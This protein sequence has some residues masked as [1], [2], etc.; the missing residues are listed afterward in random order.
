MT[1]EARST[2][3]SRL[4]KVAIAL[5]VGALASQIGVGSYVSA[6][7]PSK[8][9]VT[10]IR[11]DRQVSP[12]TVA[13]PKAE[14]SRLAAAGPNVAAATKRN[15]KPRIARAAARPAITGS[16]Y[17]ETTGG[18][19][20]TWTNY[21]NAGGYEGQQIAAFETIQVSCRLNG[22]KVPDGNTWWYQITSSPWSYAYYATADAFYN[23]GQTSGPLKGTPFFDPNVPIC[24]S[25]GGYNETTGGAANTWTDYSD[26]GGT[27]GQTIGSHATVQVTC[28]V[29]GFRVADGNTWW[30]QVASSPWNNAFFVSADA[31]YNNGQ[32][33]GSLIGTPF[34]DPSVP[35]CS[36]GAVTGSGSNETTGGAAHTWSDYSDAGGTEGQTIVAFTTVQIACKVTGFQVQDGNTWWYQIASSPWDNEYYVTADAF[37]N[38]GAT[39]G[40]LLGTPFV[41]TAVPNCS[42]GPRPGTETTGG[43]A[44]TWANYSHAGGA[45]GP[46]VPI[47]D[48]I[49][50]ACRVTGFAVSDANSWWYQIASAPWNYAYYVSADAFYN[51]GATSGSLVGT[52]FVDTSIPICVGNREAPIYGTS[53]GS[54]E[55]TTNSTSCPSGAHP[56]DCASGDFWHT[57]TD[58]SIPGR[59]P[60]LTL[61]RT[62]N[63]LDAGTLGLF[64]YGWTSSYEQHLTLTNSDASITPDGSITVTL[65][66]GS[67]F[68]AEP[69]GTGGFSV[70]LSA[71]STLVQNSDGTYTLTL[72]ATQVLTFSAIGALLSLSDLNGDRTTLT[73][74]GSSQLT[75]VTDSAGRTLT[76]NYGS[77]G[78]VAS[79]AD[80][81]GRTTTYT[82]DATNDLTSVTD[83]LG[84]TWTFTYDGSHR[85]L[86]MTDPRG[87]VVTNVYDPTGR[88]T[89]QTDADGLTTTYSYTGDN[90]SSLGGTTTITDPHGNVEVQQYANGFVTTVTKAEGTSAQGTWSYVYDPNTF[91]VT[92]ATDPNGHVTTNS[93]DP[94]GDLLTTTDPLGNETSYTY[95]GLDEVLTRTTPL[96]EVSPKTYDVEG[97]VLTSTDAVGNTTIYAYGDTTHPGDITSITDPDGRV[98]SFTYDAD[99]DVASKSVE[100]TSGTLDTTTFTVDSDGEQVCEASANADGITCP[101]AGSPHE[102]GTTTTVYDADGEVTSVTDANGNTTSR[103]YDADGNMIKVADPIGNET[104]STYDLDDR[105]VSTET[106]ANGTSP[107]TTS[108]SYDVTPGQGACQAVSGATYCRTTTDPNGGMTIEY[109]D[110]RG[111]EIEAVMPGGAET[112]FTYD[113]NGNKTSATDAAARVTTYSYDADDRLTSIVYSDG[114]T[115]DVTY[116]YDADGER[117]SMADGTGTTTYTY[118]ADGRVTSVTD[119]RGSVAGYAYDGQEDVTSLT[120]PNGQRVVR[121]YDGAERLVSVTDWLGNETTFAYDPSGNLTRTGYPNGDTVTSTYDA[122]NAL[123]ATSVSGTAGMLA[124][125]TYTRNADG[126]ITQETR[127]GAI[128]GS[129]AY[130]F[131]A[132]AE[133][134]SAGGTTFAYDLDGNLT[135]NGSSAQTFNSVDELTTTTSGVGATTYGYDAIGDR[136]SV[137]P[138]VGP[139]TDYSYDQ[140]GRLTSASEFASP[141]AVSSVAPASGPLTGGATVTISGSGFTSARAVTFGGVAATS[142][143]VVSDSE[144]R[145]DAPAASA[146]MVD[147]TVTTPFGGSPSVAGDEYTYTSAPAVTGITPPTGPTAGG[148]TVTITGTGLTGAT[149]VAF[150]TVA[151]VS[152]TV[153][154]STEITAVS[155]AH[156]AGTVGIIVTTPGGESALVAPD[157]FIFG[158]LPTVTKISPASGPLAGGTVVS[159]T[160]TG[161]SS[162]SRVLFGS[163]PAKSVT[164]LSTAK[165][166]AVSPAQAAANVQISVTTSAGTSPPVTADQ[167]SYLPIP[168]VTGVSPT[169]GSTKGGTTVSISGTGFTGATKVAFGAAAATHLTVASSTEI[170]VVDPAHA[171]GAVNVVVTGPGGKSPAVATSK[172]TYTTKTKVVA[173][174]AQANG[175]AITIQLASYA[176]NGDG[177][178]VT[179]S[180]S[181]GVM[182]F[183][184]DAT[185]SVPELLTDGSFDY[186]YGPAGLPIEQIDASNTAAYFFHDSDGSTRALLAANGAV[187]ATFTY[188]AYGA[189]SSSTGT[190]KTALLFAQTYSDPA[191]GL[192]YAVHRFY[193]PNTA[194]FTSVDPIVSQT[195]EPYS[196]ASD[197]PI[198]DRD[199]NGSCPWWF[200]CPVW[201]F[202]YNH[203]EAAQ[204]IG[205]IA[206]IV[207][208]AV[209]IVG[210]VFTATGL[211][212]DDAQLIGCITSPDASCAAIRNQ[213]FFDAAVD[214]LGIR[215][216]ELAS[217]ALSIFLL[218]QGTAGSPG[219]GNLSTPVVTSRMAPRC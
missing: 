86:T 96:G 12:R 94:A 104:L 164:R 45:E 50:I 122:T 205:T 83:P 212:V 67:Q 60:G 41:D 158:S 157:Q 185:T 131:D 152:F 111:N 121:A 14:F 53:I 78:L 120:Y 101:P 93:Y 129:T 66:D 75:A 21:T 161:F 160:G 9:P 169:S 7:A 59:G 33:T 118:N 15:S 88:V 28:A 135:A 103:T 47:H 216:P 141:P 58:V 57:F 31:F 150:G 134:S 117:A 213:A 114:V 148:T 187:G 171:K 18:A 25:G 156:A 210:L 100:P 81:L 132:K 203:S 72:H 177:L 90:F 170:T 95:N 218:L 80:P 107:S 200:L 82:Y 44:N 52:P 144:I 8:R 27:Q 208:I 139:G 197:D 74:N 143:T 3:A 217:D 6:S 51:N 136:T 1:N 35:V 124:S 207:G 71:G 154:S 195:G 179:E 188:G 102:A 128:T 26:A 73:Y 20:N 209:P 113:L 42:A 201:S 38:D 162:A 181:S 127:A 91:G 105:V 2:G 182:S 214:A 155:P 36:G 173:G 190:L 176:Y 19:A 166:S 108:Y 186:L 24:G 191:T 56:V 112:E 62:Y 196:Y 198:N 219:L 48:T 4:R 29:T 125:I 34:V 99:G 194:Q 65:G 63:D 204:N 133:L 168:S 46:T 174:S 32:T 202:G 137:S 172:F 87:G 193:D 145:A 10:S 97:N 13:P 84:R 140:T 165:L 77:N 85:M 23:N 39:S 76:L 147:I 109:F 189:E 30:Y 11:L 106:G 175:T 130:A 16:T 40:S 123:M 70:P 64:G 206:Q 37:Y 138:A 17:S 163:V 167:F 49:Q 79:V 184:W 199:P 126:L 22:F 119:G 183:T 159:I 215:L 142:F 110:A 151:A 192:L 116:T 149:T 180:T 61:T 68:V 153:V 115:P 178:R 89:S 43:A 211:V 54:S 98:T 5:V 55:A 69:N 146:G 92:A